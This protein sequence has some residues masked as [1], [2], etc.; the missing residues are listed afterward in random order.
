MNVGYRVMANLATAAPFI[1]AIMAGMGSVLTARTLRK[2][3][4]LTL[5]I[6]AWTEG[7]FCKCWETGSFMKMVAILASNQRRHLSQTIHSLVDY[8]MKEPAAYS[9]Y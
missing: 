2:M 6:L 4:S 8:C 5:V 3:L 7:G 9:M 1:V